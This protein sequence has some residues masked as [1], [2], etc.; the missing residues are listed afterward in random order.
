MLSIPALEAPIQVIDQGAWSIKGRRKAQEDAFILHE[1]HDTKDRSILLAGVFD[2]HLGAAASSFARD[3]L[4]G[5]FSASLNLGDGAPVQS[6]LEISWNQCCDSYRASCLSE[7]DCVAEY[8]PK[9]GIL[10][11][12]TGSQDAVAGTTATVFALDK[13]TSHLAALNCGDSRGLVMD[14]NGQLVFQTIDHKPESEIERLTAGAEQGLGYSIPKCR[15]ARWTLEVGDYDYAVARSLEGSFATSKGI[16][17]L[18]DVSVLQA[19]S[20]MTALVAT[21]GL[22]E[23]IDSAEACRIVSR[24]KSQK[25]SASDAAKA[26]C[27]LAY[28]KATTDNVSVVVIYLD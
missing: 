15:V 18:A 1:V 21:D 19:E 22:W 7:D 25:A 2:G 6:L 24:L 16:V 5:T 26:L 4:P 13:Q 9:E 28:E 3:D 11:A 10:M 14:S 8:D 20:G 17:S 12:Y 27:S 23:V